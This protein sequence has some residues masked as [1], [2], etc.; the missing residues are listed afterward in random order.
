ME[1]IPKDKM[2]L[3]KTYAAHISFVNQCKTNKKNQ[4]YLFTT[5]IHDEC[6]F[7]WKFIYE[8][9]LWDL[10]NL[11]Y[12]SNHPDIFSEIIPRQ[13]FNEVIEK[14]L[15]LRKKISDVLLKVEPRNK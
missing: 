12:Q 9:L 14:E 1:S 6:I 3:A 15:P 10:D 2:C 11:E 8:E 5:G 13:Q 7:K 4:D